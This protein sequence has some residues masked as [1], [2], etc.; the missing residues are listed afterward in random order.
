MLSKWRFSNQQIAIN[1][2]GN[3][4]IALVVRLYDSLSIR[5]NGKRGDHQFILYYDYVY[6]LYSDTIKMSNHSTYI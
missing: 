6:I 4:I 5:L 3:A 1:I 2:F